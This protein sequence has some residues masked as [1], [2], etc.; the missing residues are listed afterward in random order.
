MELAVNLEINRSMDLW[1]PI[2]ITANMQQNER[3]KTVSFNL[4][5][6]IS[7][8]VLWSVLTTTITINNLW[9]F[10]FQQKFIRTHNQYHTEFDVDNQCLGVSPSPCRYIYT[11]S[12][13]I[14]GPKCP[15]KCQ[16]HTRNLS[17]CDFLGAILCFR[18]SA[19][20]LALSLFPFVWNVTYVFVSERVCVC[21]TRLQMKNIKCL[22]VF[23]WNPTEKHFISLRVR[24]RKR[25]YITS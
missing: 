3:K 6:I 1:Q 23:L 5:K 25:I 12:L 14:Y 16:S 20:L 13:S 21:R 7:A 15:I 18:S 24:E 22:T 4:D 10:E 17:C 9:F 11:L 8:W 2:E 19:F